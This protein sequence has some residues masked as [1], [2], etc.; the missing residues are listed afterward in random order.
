MRF[1]LTAIQL[2]IL[3]SSPTL[4]SDYAIPLHLVSRQSSY[5]CIPVWLQYP[6]PSWHACGNGYITPGCSCCPGDLIGCL[7]LTQT[8]KIGATGVSFCCDN[9]SPDCLPTQGGGGGC[10]AEGKVPCGTGCLPAGYGCCANADYEGGCPLDQYCCSYP[11]GTPACCAANSDTSTPSST[12]TIQSSER[13]TSPTSKAA[14]TSTESSNFETG[15]STTTSTKTTSND[16][17]PTAISDSSSSILGH[18]SSISVTSSPISGHSSSISGPSSSISRSSSTRVYVV[19][20]ARGSHSFIF[21]SAMPF[22]LIYCFLL[23]GIFA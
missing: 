21:E 4:A 9:T 7:T 5:F 16:A 20:A 12:A 3:T 17:T 1:L 8:C 15:S 10:V 11:D 23:V 14:P 2:I 19:G 18:S 6:S 22:I 13:L